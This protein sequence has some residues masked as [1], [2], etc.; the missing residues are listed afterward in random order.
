[1]YFPVVASENLSLAPTVTVFVTIECKSRFFFLSLYPTPQSSL[2][3]KRI[4]NTNR[5]LTNAETNGAIQHTEPELLE[6]F[7][8]PSGNVTYIE[9]WY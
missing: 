1:M 2:A 8:V 3:A 7:V 9:R 4:D 6:F 5:R